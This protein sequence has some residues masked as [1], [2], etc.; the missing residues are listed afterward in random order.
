MLITA[1]DIEPLLRYRDW[2]VADLNAVETLNTDATADLEAW[3]GR[4]IEVAEF[5]EQVFVEYDG[6]GYARVFPARTPIRT[7]VTFTEDDEDDT[8]ATVVRAERSDIV[9]AGVPTR[10]TSFTL[11]Y[12]AGMGEP[13]LSACRSAVRRRLTRLIQKIGDDSVGTESA[14]FEAYTARYFSE[15]FTEDELKPLQRFRRKAI[16]SSPPA[17]S[18]AG[19][20]IGGMYGGSWTEWAPL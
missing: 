4:T 18:P 12:T 15:G 5:N 6:Q 1:A 7:L 19:T 16:A 10:S 9:I 11:V 3:L 13:C 20:V 14:T 17:A 2:S 8:P